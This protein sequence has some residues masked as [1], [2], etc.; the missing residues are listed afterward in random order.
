MN[1]INHVRRPG[2]E[3]R[4]EWPVHSMEHFRVLADTDFSIK[5]FRPKFDLN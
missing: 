1:F 3:D 4:S 5:V 2:G